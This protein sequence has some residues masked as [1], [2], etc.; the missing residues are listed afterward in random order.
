MSKGLCVSAVVILGLVTCP[1]VGRASSLGVETYAASVDD[2]SQ[3][4]NVYGQM[5]VHL[6]LDVP[7]SEVVNRCRCSRSSTVAITMSRRR[8]MSRA[9][10]KLA[11]S[12]SPSD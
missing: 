1:H 9:T 7:L 11:P 6:G 4:V 3:T 2:V 5:V 10:P 12:V 8:P